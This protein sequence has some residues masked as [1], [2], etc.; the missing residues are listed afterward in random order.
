LWVGQR[1][2]I[3]VNVQIQAAGHV[4][5]GDDVIVGPGVRIWSAN[6]V[7]KNPDV[8][9]NQQGAEYKEV[10]IEDDT[11]IGAGAFIMPGTHMGR[12][13]VISAGA[14]VGGKAY[15]DFSILAGNPA[16]VIGFRKPQPTR[17]EQA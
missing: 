8:P 10:V 14:V 12:G 15:K 2:G 9:I 5:L 1:T 17:E 7:Y 4:R 3:S 6:H 16:R 11:W 13:C